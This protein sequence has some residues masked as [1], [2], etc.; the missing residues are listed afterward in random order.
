MIR[1]SG[2]MSGAYTMFGMTLPNR[3]LDSALFLHWLPRV[4]RLRNLIAVVF[5]LTIWLGATQHCNLEAAGIFD[6]ETETGR[7]CCT[8]SEHG[9]R[10]DGCMEVESGSYRPSASTTLVAL[11]ATLGCCCY[12]CNVLVTPPT[13]VTLAVKVRVAV[14]QIKPWV[15]AWH[16]ERRAVAVPG[17]PELI[18]A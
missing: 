4:P 18:L 17:A 9:C 8:G 1:P 15:P 12:L 5:A 10:V 7:V 16:F 6:H 11:P 13:E 3:L 14:G 2:V